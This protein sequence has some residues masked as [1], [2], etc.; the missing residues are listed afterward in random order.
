MPV[1]IHAG[2]SIL[3]HSFG[4][5]TI[6]SDKMNRLMPLIAPLDTARHNNSTNG[7]HFR[8]GGSWPRRRLNLGFPELDPVGGTNSDPFPLGFDP[9]KVL[10]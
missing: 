1:M 5:L 8:T 9:M 6:K 4:L 10:C 2:P 7:K 3:I